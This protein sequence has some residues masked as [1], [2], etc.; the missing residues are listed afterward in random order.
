MS[1]LYLYENCDYWQ[2]NGQTARRCHK[3]HIKC[4]NNVESMFHDIM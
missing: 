3:F 4:Q 2:K 1:K